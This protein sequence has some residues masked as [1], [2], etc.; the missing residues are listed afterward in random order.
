MVTFCNIAPFVFAALENLDITQILS[1]QD[2]EAVYPL[3]KIK[4]L[5]VH[6]KFNL[7]ALLFAVKCGIPCKP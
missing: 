7:A 2:G 5:A 3:P 4:S 1:A 6:P